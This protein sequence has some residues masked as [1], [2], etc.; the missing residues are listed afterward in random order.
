MALGFR[1]FFKTWFS[2]SLGPPAH[3]CLHL[4]GPQAF[5]QAG[6]PLPLCQA[7]PYSSCRAQITHQVP[8][9]ACLP[10][11]TFFLAPSAPTSFLCFSYPPVYNSSGL[12]R[13]AA[14]GTFGW[15]VEGSGSGHQHADPASHGRKARRERKDRLDNEEEEMSL[16]LCPLALNHQSHRLFKNEFLKGLLSPRH[17][18]EELQH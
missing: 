8:W 10:E 4:S 12:R 13:A 3:T 14:K 15:E 18:R 16:G 2:T 6:P 9:E 7:N 17:R 11:Q 1:A 5:M